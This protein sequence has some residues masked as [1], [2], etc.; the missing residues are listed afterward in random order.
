MSTKIAQ[1][2][3]ALADSVRASPALLQHPGQ[4]RTSPFFANPSTSVAHIPHA[5]NVNGRARV[6]AN[7]LRTDAESTFTLNTTSL[8]YGWTLNCAI[9][10]GANQGAITEGWGFQAIRSIEITLGASSIGPRVLEGKLVREYLMMVCQGP[11]E[12]RQVLRNAGK[13]FFNGTGEFSIPI[14][15]LISRAI[16]ACADFPLDMSAMK[17]PITFRVR[18]RPSRDFIVGTVSG[19]GVPPAPVNIPEWN[20]V[21]LVASST[22]LIDRRFSAGAMLEANPK[23]DYII[24]AKRLTNVQ[25]AIIANHTIGNEIF[26]TNN[27][28]PVGMLEAIIL[29]I[30]PDAECASSVATSAALLQGSVGIDR[31]SVRH[32]GQVLM[33]AQSESEYM[34]YLR[35]H[36]NGDDLRQQYDYFGPRHSTVTG[37]PAV[38]TGINEVD[39]DQGQNLDVGTIVIPLSFHSRNVASY[40]VHESLP[41]YSSATLEFQITTKQRRRR[42]ASAPYTELSSGTISSTLGQN[43]ETGSFTIEVLYVT[44]ALLQINRDGVNL[45]DVV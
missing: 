26:F 1:Q 20:R 7:S 6:A 3:L 28:A 2:K 34:A 29:S 21:E 37:A 24:P 27:A 10:S 25:G 36:F 9:T 18:W 30:K 13:P 31:I 33:E 45:I 32:G 19:A 4:A 39:I 43:S 23:A 5:L 12:R 14:V 11:V 41:S 44:S 8:Q 17:G 42:I 40:H 35:G 16:G 38:A 22:D 15:W